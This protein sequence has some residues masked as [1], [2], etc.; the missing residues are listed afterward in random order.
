MNGKITAVINTFN[1]EKTIEQVLNS[2]SWVDEI[3][4]C[5]MH[6]DDN[7]PIIAKKLGAKVLFHKR[8]GYVEPARNFVISKASHEWVLVVDADEEIPPSLADFIKDFVNKK[9]V[10]N[11]LEIPRRNIIFGKW[12]KASMWWPDY[13]VRFF[14]KGS[15]VWGN[16][17]HSKPKVEGQGVKIPPEERWAIIHHNYNS[18]SQYLQRMIR[19]SEIQARELRKDGYKF[20]WTDLIRKPLSEFLGRF[21]ANK[22]FED[23]LHGFALSVLQAFSFFIMYLRVWEYDKFEEKDIPLNELD[24]ERKSVHEQIDYWFKYGNLPKN[25]LKRLALKAKNKLSN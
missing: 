14:K 7:T 15:V 18:V 9:T 12:M 1:E 24:L 8:V 10:S 6:S 13:H 20:D 23:G 19:Y 5:D 25:L 2:L 22:G 17:I 4:V 3:I 16:K 21:F 11:Y